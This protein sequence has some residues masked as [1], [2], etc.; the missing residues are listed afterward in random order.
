MARLVAAFAFILACAPLIQ[1]QTAAREPIDATTETASSQPA[2]AQTAQPPK[3]E[4]RPSIYD[5]IWTFTELYDKRSNPVVQSVLFSGRFHYEYAAIDA[6]QGD[7][8][9]WNMRRLRLGPRVT[10]FRTFTLH[11]E[12]ELNPQERDPLYQRFTDFYL[13]WSRSGRFA[14]TLGKHGVLF[15]MDGS[16]SSRELLTID[17]SNLTNNI[18]FPQSTC[19]AS[20][21]RGGSRPG[22]IVRVSILQGQ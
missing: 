12:V 22:S 14:V 3:P 4:K 21:C 16:T 2:A 19:R 18:W 8:D 1:A 13:Q 20:A 5:K 11:A 15:T 10:L 9:E 6:D 17:R 7:L